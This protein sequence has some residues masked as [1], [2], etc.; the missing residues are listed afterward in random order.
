[1]HD[2]PLW[3]GLKHT[4]TPLLFIVGE[5]DTKFKSIAHEMCYTI[6][7]GRKTSDDSSCGVYELVEIP[8][9]GHAPHLENPLPV[10]SALRRFT[11]KLADGK[12]T[13]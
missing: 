3:E 1:M 13:L 4:K 2:R 8:K 6:D 10:V 11:C 5:K 9:S 12:E 7:S